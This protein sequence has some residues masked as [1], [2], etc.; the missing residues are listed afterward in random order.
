MVIYRTKVQVFNSDKQLVQEG[1]LLQNNQNDMV[2]YVDS[3]YRCKEFASINDFE[4]LAS[5]KQ[6]TL[7]YSMDEKLPML[8]EYKVVLVNRLKKVKAVL[9]LDS[10]GY[11]YRGEGKGGNIGKRDFFSAFAYF[12]AMTNPEFKLKI[13]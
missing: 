2:Y 3:F 7:H 10:S 13:A 11:S 12:T 1:N 4:K 6:F 8:D 9:T 5:D